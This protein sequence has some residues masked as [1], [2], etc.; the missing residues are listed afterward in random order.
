M[1][2]YIISQDYEHQEMS[3]K[4]SYFQKKKKEGK[5]EKF[6]Y[7]FNLQIEFEKNKF[8]K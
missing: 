7:S 3:L 2:I 4:I 5:L 8:Y 1:Q 6:H